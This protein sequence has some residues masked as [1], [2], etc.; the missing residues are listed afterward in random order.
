MYSHSGYLLD[1]MRETTSSISHSSNRLKSGMKQV[2]ERTRGISR[3]ICF[4]K[5]RNCKGKKYKVK[6]RPAAEPE[7]SPVSRAWARI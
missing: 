2:T 7:E 5:P 1:H 4:L 6:R 3:E